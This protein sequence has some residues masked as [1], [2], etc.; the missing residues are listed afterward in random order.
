[1][2]YSKLQD[3][4]RGS[5]VGGAVGDVLGYEVEFMSLSAIRKRFGAEGITRYVLH[6]GVGH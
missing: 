1:M 2:E 6:N 3:K 5:L 4:C